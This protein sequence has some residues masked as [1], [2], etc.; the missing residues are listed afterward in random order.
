MS[1]VRVRFAPSPTGWLHVG[2]ARTAYFNWLFARQRKG[3]LVLRIEDTD[4]AR[5]D[6]GLEQGVLDDLA[7]LGLDWDEGPDRPGP[8]G[9]Y[10]Q[11]E[12]L[13]LY[14]ERA[15]ALLE[16]GRAFRCYCTDDELEIARQS[17]LAAGRP[18]QYN[19]RCRKLAPAESAARAAAGESHTIRFAVDAGRAWT[20]R[21][22]VRGEVVFPAGMIGDFVLLRSS[23]LPTYN[24][25]AA[26]DDAAMRISHVI[27]AEEHLANTPRQLMVYEALDERP[28]EFAHVALILNRDRSKMSKRSGEAAV[29]VGDWRRAGFVPEALLAY[30]AL[31]G[32]HPGDDREVLTREELIEAFSLERLGR[33]GSVFDAAKLRWMNAHWLHLASGA[34]IAQW[35]ATGP[36]PGASDDWRARTDRL[37]APLSPA[38]RE[39][40]LEGVRG[41]VPTLADLPAELGVLVGERP[42]FEPEAAEALRGPGVGPLL[43]ALA[44]ELE[45]LA[46]WSGE[47]FKSALQTTGSR[48]GRRGRELFMPVRAALSGRTHGPELPL[49]AELLGRE[50]CVQRLREAVRRAG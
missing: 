34:Q 30:L 27:R 26:V 12:R 9:P 38:Q 13:A 43:D 10:R 40:L 42:A 20:L 23:G 5:S 16:A 1:D 3:T 22:H 29:A 14:R 19:G 6:R 36:G 32:F 47:G 33:S 49:L 25:A 35:L 21:D 37:L 41:N 46:Q 15:S 31:L 11:S 45:P 7:W 4:V 44:G 24:F 48:L 2:G 39:K 50:R 8:Y 28:P 18:P 17:A